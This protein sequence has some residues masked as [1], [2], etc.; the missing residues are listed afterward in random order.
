MTV[1]ATSAGRD[2]GPPESASSIRRLW[3]HGPRYVAWVLGLLLLTGIVVPW[4]SLARGQRRILAALSRALGRS[5]QARAVHLVLLPWP[6]FKLDDLRVADD[7]AFGFQPIVRAREATATLRLSALWSGQFAFSTIRLDRP[8]L[9][10]VRSA[11]GRWNLGRLVDG[12]AR[13]LPRLVQSPAARPRL[14]RRRR[15]FPCWTFIRGG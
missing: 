8:V 6:G 5:V 14:C 12:S 15:S 9:N 3:R 2:S 11:Q 4:F 13:R 1:E 10:L 7:A